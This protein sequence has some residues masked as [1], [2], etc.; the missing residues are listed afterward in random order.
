M[1]GSMER[2]EKYLSVIMKKCDEV[3]HLTDD[4]FLHSISDLNKLKVEMEKI[5]LRGFLESAVNEIAAEHDDVRL[6]LPEEEVTVLADG[7]RLVQLC[8]N[9]I[10]NA[11]KYAKTSIDVALEATG[12]EACIVFRDYGAGIPDEDMPFI[13]GNFYR[14]KNCGAEQG[15]G[16]GLYIVKYIVEKMKGRVFLQNH[17]DGLEVVITL[18]ISFSD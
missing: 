13:F 14:G 10:N 12:E 11:R 4:L 8:E 15:S 2:R 9:I 7:N 1:D 6:S 3:A 5:E 17:A 18:P 16:L